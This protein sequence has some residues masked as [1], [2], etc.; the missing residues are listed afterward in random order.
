MKRG[1]SRARYSIEAV[2]RLARICALFSPER[3]ELD[4]REI[5]HLSGIPVRTAAKIATTL[6]RRDFLSRPDDTRRWALGPAWLRLADCKRSHIDVRAASIPI[7][8]WIREDLNE[9]IIV[10]V[11]SGNRRIIVECMVSTQPIRRLSAVG[12]ETLL[13]V[14]SSGRTILAGLSDDEIASYLANVRLV[15]YGYDTVTDPARI[16]SDVRKSRRDGYLTARAEIT[17]GSLSSSAAIRSYAG[18]IVAA[19]TIT[20]PLSRLTDELRDRSIRLVTEG[21]QRISHRLGYSVTSKFDP[22]ET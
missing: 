20:F 1:V 3:R 15:N 9:T 21:A 5:A 13:H 22:H 18:E 8:R 14:G 17:K 7:M 2:Q 6:E 19:L 4:L 11:R 12:D 16:W 10:A